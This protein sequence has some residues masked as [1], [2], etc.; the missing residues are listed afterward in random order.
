MA[1]RV[2]D[3]G[4]AEGIAIFET[5]LH[6]RFLIAILILNWELVIICSKI[7]IH[8]KIAIQDQCAR[9]TK[10]KKKGKSVQQSGRLT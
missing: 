7:A 1:K 10:P 4:S 3:I 2:T 8:P 5:G 9:V 6:Y